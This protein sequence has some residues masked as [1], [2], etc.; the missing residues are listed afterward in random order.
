MRILYNIP[1]A[2]FY[3]LKG[4]HGAFEVFVLCVKTSRSLGRGVECSMVSPRSL[5]GDPMVQGLK[6]FWFRA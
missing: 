3:L 4:A 6:D 1:K 2:I 5:S